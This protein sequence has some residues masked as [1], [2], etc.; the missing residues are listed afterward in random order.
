MCVNLLPI[1]IIT[2]VEP[3]LS[4]N[5]GKAMKKQSSLKQLFLVK[6]NTDRGSKFY[7]FLQNLYKHSEEK[8]TAV[9]Q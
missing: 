5:C 9:E 8:F 7:L 3:I 2:E 1:Y 4:I 6:E